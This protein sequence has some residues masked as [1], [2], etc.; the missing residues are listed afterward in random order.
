MTPPTSTSTTPTN[1]AELISFFIGFINYF[2]I[3]LIGLTFIV[4]IW[5]LIDAWIIHVDNDTKRK[6]GMAVAGTAAVVM[7]IMLS[8]WGILA[9]LQNSLL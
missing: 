2:I 4:V 7:A 9:L 6:E 5:K 8:I 3:L 1:F